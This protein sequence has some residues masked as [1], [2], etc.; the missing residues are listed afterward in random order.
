MLNTTLVKKYSQRNTYKDGRPSFHRRQRR[1][2]LSLDLDS[3]IQ[4]WNRRRVESGREVNC[5]LGTKKSN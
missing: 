4:V 2:Y 5:S 1:P 3:S